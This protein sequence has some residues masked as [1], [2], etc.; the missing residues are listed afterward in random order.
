VSSIGG[1]A[2]ARSFDGDSDDSDEWDFP[3][4]IVAGPDGR[5]T[6]SG[7]SMRDTGIEEIGT[8][9]DYV[10]LQY[11]ADGT[12]LWR[13]RVERNDWSTVAFFPIGPAIATKSNGSVVL[14]GAIGID[15]AAE[16]LLV[17]YGP[18]GDELFRI[19]VPVVA[20]GMRVLVDSTD[21]IYV[22]AGALFVKDDTSMYRA[23][24]L[25]FSP[26]GELS[27]QVA[28]EPGRNGWP[29]GLGFHQGGLVLA[30][31]RSVYGEDTAD[32]DAFFWGLD[33]DGTTLWKAGEPV[34]GG[35]ETYCAGYISAFTP[36]NR[37]GSCLGRDESG[38]TYLGGSSDWDSFNGGMAQRVVKLDASGRVEWSR[39]FE[40]EGEGVYNEGATALA[41]TPNGVARLG[42]HY[43]RDVRQGNS[44]T[45]ESRE[46][47]VAFD[48]AGN[49]LAPLELSIGDPVAGVVFDSAGAAYLLG[50]FATL[51]KVLLP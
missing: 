2:W 1:L 23:T 36:R 33:F 27:W 22:A 6:V 50:A 21:R 38:A 7:F 13:A 29:A 12:E 39:Q 44:V 31:T 8:V 26:A 16:L 43:Y 41:S 37:A 4:M 18:S 46:V 9:L 10:T 30:G 24:V 45:T 32:S 17:E 15:D 40:V 3:S 11:G 42:G 48:A 25:G 49:Q 28:T 35:A 47:T 51:T 19:E 5:V 34:R 20:E 14:T